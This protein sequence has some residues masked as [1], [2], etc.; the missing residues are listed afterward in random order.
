MDK[1][2]QRDIFTKKNTTYFFCFS[3]FSPNFAWRLWPGFPI[4]GH[5]HNLLTKLQA[6]VVQD[7][8]GSI[9]DCQGQNT[10][11]EISDGCCRPEFS[12]MIP[13]L[14]CNNTCHEG[15]EGAYGKSG[16]FYVT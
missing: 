1:M 4:D 7:T 6:P 15:M 13:L 2:Y 12:D 9:A 5:I 16:F 14:I 8:V 3:S 10:A 11:L